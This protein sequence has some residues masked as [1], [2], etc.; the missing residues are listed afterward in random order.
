[1]KFLPSI[2]LILLFFLPSCNI[3]DP[4][5]EI[6]AYIHI[7][8]ISVEGESNTLRLPDAWVYCNEELIGVFEMPATVPVLYS[9]TTKVKIRAGIKANGLSAVRLPY[10]FYNKYEASVELIPKQTLTINPVVS[11]KI[12]NP[13]RWEEKFES[14]SLGIESTS[15]SDTTILITNINTYEGGHCGMVKIDSVRKSYEG[16]SVNTYASEKGLPAFLEIHYRS[17]IGFWCGIF[18]NE[19]GGTAAPIVY[20]YKSEEWNKMYIDVGSTFSKYP[21]SDLFKVFFSSSLSG[22]ARTNAY[23]C[24]DNIKLIY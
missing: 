16:M 12:S 10:P 3:F 19:N 18:V 21:K 5:E 22:L 23:F 24:L 7:D 14:I 15:L 17:D 1:M 13:V 8:K 20:V 11:Y 9:N 6:P 4:D 2:W